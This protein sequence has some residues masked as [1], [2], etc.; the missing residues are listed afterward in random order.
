MI[1]YE[2]SYSHPHRHSISFKA[3]FPSSGFHQIQLQLPS[4][5]PG[6]YELGNF[7][8]NI[9]HWKAFASNGEQLS[10]RKITKD[11]WEVDTNGSPVVHITYDYYAADLNAGSS[12]LD[13]EMLYI[14]PVN[15]F[16]FDPLQTNKKYH[17]TFHLPDE[18][19][20]ACGLHKE[21]SHVLLAENFDELADAPLI[22]SAK[23]QHV[24]YVCNNITFHIWMKGDVIP[25][26][27]KLARDFQLFTQAHFDIFGDI[28]CN[29]YHFLFHFPSHF[30]RHGVEHHNSTVIAMGPATEF[31]SGNGYADLLAI[32][33]HELFHTWNVKSIRPIEMMPYD[34]TK[35]NYSE[36]GYVA[37]GIT[38]YYGDYLLYRCGLMNEDGWQ[39]VLAEAIQEHMLN[40]G[41]FNLSVAQSSIETWLDGYTP[42]I[43]WRKVSIYNEGCLIAYIAD[44][45]IKKFTNNQKSLDDVMRLMYE[46]FG[47]TGI[48]YSSADYKFILEEVGGFSFDEIFAK[49]YNGT[50]D[51]LPYIIQALEINGYQLMEGPSPKYS[52]SNLGMSI[53]ETG[54][55]NTISFILKD[56]PADQAGLWYSDEV[57]SIN[58]IHAYKNMQSL[59]RLGGSEL[60]VEFSRK[61]K[62]KKAVL[63]NGQE[64]FMKRYFVAKKSSITSSTEG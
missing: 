47:K 27:E 22:A 26:K 10:Y 36:L 14:N 51:Y 48:G 12:Y 25:D 8:K 32:S 38:T 52:E 16:L 50:S 3:T 56:G 17:V 19:Q 7:A 46:R 62:T 43:P 64:V 45:L 18:Y 23:L 35:E 53:D 44:A 4:W 33:C 63:L 21:S 6:R 13:E 49:L 42:G 61:N 55:K 20:L 39:N 1:R 40:Q 54:G 24:S 41:R 60:T 29:E 34:F 31:V 15:C 11:L 28:P 5:R 37:E 57:I 59:L 58:G 2:V 9:L 30:I